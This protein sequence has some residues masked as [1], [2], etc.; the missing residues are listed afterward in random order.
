MEGGLEGGRGT[1]RR[2]EKHGEGDWKAGG[3][4]D[5]K[6]GGEAWKGGLEGDT[7]GRGGGRA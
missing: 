2:E 7:G 3:E 6:A 5:W 4:G 1:G